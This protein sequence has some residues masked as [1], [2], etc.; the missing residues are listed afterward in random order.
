M[1]LLKDIDDRV[2]SCDRKLDDF[3]A[4]RRPVRRGMRDSLVT[5]DRPVHTFARRFPMSRSDVFRRLLIVLVGG[6]ITERR[7]AGEGGSLASFGARVDAARLDRVRDSIAHA[8][9][10]SDNRL[11]GLQRYPTKGIKYD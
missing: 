11:E 4:I 5:A 6:L 7:K 1:F 8:E 2:L 3:G 9:R 10:F